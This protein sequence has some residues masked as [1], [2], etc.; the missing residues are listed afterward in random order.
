LLWQLEDVFIKKMEVIEGIYSYPITNSTT[1]EVNSFYDV[2]PFP[3]YTNADNN[4]SIIEKGDTNPFSNKLKEF[5]G[6]KKSFLEVGAGTCQLS[7][8]LAIG[9]NNE[10]YALDP[11]LESLKLGINFAEKSSFRQTNLY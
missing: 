4:L 2:E 3:N 9:T 8:Y 6:Y 11:T 7:N 10:I 1:K 5:I